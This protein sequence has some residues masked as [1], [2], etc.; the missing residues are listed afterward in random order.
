MS[1]ENF[2]TEGDEDIVYPINNNFEAQRGLLSDFI[3]NLSNGN[4]FKALLIKE[5][6]EKDIS[7]DKSFLEGDNIKEAAIDGIETSLANGDFASVGIIKE[8]FLRR[9]S[10][11]Y[12]KIFGVLLLK[13]AE[14]SL[15]EKNYDKLLEMQKAHFLDSSIIA[16]PYFEELVVEKFNSYLK[17]KDF[18]KLLEMQKAGFIS[19]EMLNNQELQELSN[20]RF[21]FLLKTNI[22][23]AADI[24]KNFPA[25]SKIFEASSEDFLKNC[26]NEKDISKI[27]ELKENNLIDLNNLKQE[28]AKDLK[29]LIVSDFSLSIS[30][31][32]DILKAKKIRS[33]FKES[34]EEIN[35]IISQKI[36]EC[37]NDKDIERLAIIKDGLDVDLDSL[38]IS[39]INDFIKNEFN[40]STEKGDLVRTQMIKK[41][42]P[43][44][45]TRG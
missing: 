16:D 31:N 20:N 44:T 43:R 23:K 37:L 15:R 36:I 39:G 33:T 45:L 3:S 11:E 4:I 14:L 41:A 29:E 18:D 19:N 27:I 9:E 8:S 32:I 12:E 22:N 24:N 42:F 5:E 40:L 7:F 38:N 2:S 1:Y 26:L 35:K 25:Q 17:E 13:E 21:I 30:K 10:G 28:E 6:L 34:G